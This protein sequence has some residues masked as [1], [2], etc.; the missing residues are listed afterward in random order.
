MQ[1]IAHS[2][3]SF[4]L[5]NIFELYIKDSKDKSLVFINEFEL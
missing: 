2:Q 3:I 4:Y 5:C 1:S